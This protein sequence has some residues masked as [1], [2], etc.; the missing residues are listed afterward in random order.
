MF[1]A[2]QATNQ[3]HKTWLLLL[4]AFLEGLPVAGFSGFPPTL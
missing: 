1:V 2:P 3:H 4:S